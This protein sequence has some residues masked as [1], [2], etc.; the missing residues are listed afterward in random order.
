MKKLIL[1]GGLCLTSALYSNDDD[2]APAPAR[3]SAFRT[4]Q[5]SS[6]E[7]MR[8]ASQQRQA[9]FRTMQ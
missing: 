4:A 7:R 8:Q 6:L 5:G 9:A 2:K 3:P 1:I